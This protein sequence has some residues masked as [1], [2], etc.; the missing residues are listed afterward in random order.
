MRRDGEFWRGDLGGFGNVGR[1]T[2]TDVGRDHW[3]WAK[4]LEVEELVVVVM[5]V[6]TLWVPFRTILKKKKILIPTILG[7]FMFFE[8]VGSSVQQLLRLGVSPSVVVHVCVT[9][10]V[11]IV[12]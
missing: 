7:A 10:F 12:G 2:P 9:S 5:M 8:L 4:P 6:M 1:E 3:V 11:F